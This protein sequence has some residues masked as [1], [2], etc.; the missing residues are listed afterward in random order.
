MEDYDPCT[1][2][3][4]RKQ[5]VIDEKI[6]MLEML[7]LPLIYPSLWKCWVPS[8]DGIVMLYCIDSRSSFVRVRAI[9]HK[10]I[11]TLIEKGR[12][13]DD[14]PLFLVG[15]KS[16]CLKTREVSRAEGIAL[17]R[18]FCCGFVEAS[19]KVAMHVEEPFFEI[20][21]AFRRQEPRMIET[22][23]TSKRGRKAAYQRLFQFV[24]QLF[25]RRLVRGQNFH[26]TVQSSG[27]EGSLVLNRKLVKASIN[28]DGQAL[29]TQLDYRVKMD[30]QSAFH[31]A[32][33]SGHS[34]IVKL[35]LAKGVDFSAKGRGDMR[36]LQV[37]AS[38][39]HASIV[40]LLLE[41]GA[42]VDERTRL[43]GTA[44]ICASSRAHLNVVRVLLDHGADVNAKGGFYGN[45]LQAAAA[46]GKV[47]LA[48]LLL[49]SGANVDAAGDGGYTALQ[50]AAFPGK[51]DLI[52]LL[53]SRGALPDL[54][55]ATPSPITTSIVAEE[56]AQFYK[57]A[58]HFDYGD[59]EVVRASAQVIVDLAYYG[60]FVSAKQI[61]EEETSK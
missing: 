10:I 35:L 47:D 30:E 21:R 22:F 16:D 24:C 41:D 36:P 53:L 43:H 2:N 14:F 34:K 61:E 7:E 60:M 40:C 51:F 32:A 52:E 28:N 37:A 27:I 45:A 57:V 19:T 49:D 4:W 48:R 6:C 3:N 33:A 8:T 29:K 1:D 59:S 25:Q 20:V 42:P 26:T 38:E 5:V 11:K 12:D 23:N 50:V 17:A 39:G 54:R 46:L 15:N 44:L 58:S 13:V 9:Y 18:E 55:L 56:D 31:A